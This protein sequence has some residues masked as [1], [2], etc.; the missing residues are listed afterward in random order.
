[1]TSSTDSDSSGACPSPAR[2]QR[3]LVVLG[4]LGTLVTAVTLAYA[5]TY[6]TGYFDTRFAKSSFERQRSMRGVPQFQRDFLRFTE[7]LKR[8]LP[9]GTKVLVEAKDATTL[10]GQARWFLYMTYMAY[11]VRVYVRRP[12]LASGT[13]VDYPRWLNRELKG[14]SISDQ[15]RLIKEVDELGIEWR[16]R[17]RVHKRF[18][19]DQLEIARR[20]DG[21]WIDVTI[22][23]MLGERIES[24]NS[25]QD[26]INFY[27]E[28]D[29]QGDSDLIESPSFE[30]QGAGGAR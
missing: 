16:L 6:T 4:L 13:L 1:M 18:Q 14:A 28:D 10:S 29:L 7:L 8:T 27:G 22:Q 9:P 20:E 30:G 2:P 5:I 15:F 12:E 25:A 21:Q 26:E 11:P 3:G 17:Y 23:E 19:I 24:D